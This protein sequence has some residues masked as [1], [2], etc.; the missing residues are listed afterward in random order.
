MFSSSNALVDEPKL[1]FFQSCQLV[2]RNADLLSA[3][4]SDLA[5]AELEEWNNHGIYV[6]TVT[7]ELEDEIEYVA[8]VGKTKSLRRR[9]QEYK[10]NFQAH[11]PNDYKLQVFQ[12]VVRSKNVNASFR[13]YFQPGPVEKLTECENRSIAQLHPMLNQRPNIPAEA[14]REFL[15]AFESYYSAG[16]SSLFGSSVA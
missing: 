11:S 10:R 16:F 4:S 9:V 1:I 13:L 8:Y 14:R 15:A 5:K 3:E 2:C 6:W 12:R 7:T